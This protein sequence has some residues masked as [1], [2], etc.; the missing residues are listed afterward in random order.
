M[1]TISY[2]FYFNLIIILLFIHNSKQNDLRLGGLYRYSYYPSIQF[3]LKQV[4]R[5][6][7][8]TT[9][10][11]QFL[12]ND[13]ERIIDVNMRVFSSFLFILFLV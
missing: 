9:K 8:N 11:F 2:R 10:N 1:G 7:Q 3:A 12:L 13:T 6:F 5:Y 4:N